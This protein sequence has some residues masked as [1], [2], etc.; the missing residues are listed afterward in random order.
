MTTNGHHKIYIKLKVE[1]HEPPL[2]P[3]VSKVL[4]KVKM[5]QFAYGHIP[6]YTERHICYGKQL[7]CFKSIFIVLLCS[8]L[9]QCN[10]I[11]LRPYIYYIFQ[12][13]F[14][15]FN[16]YFLYFVC[17]VLFCFV[18]VFVFFLLSYLYFE[19]IVFSDAI[20]SLLSIYGKNDIW[21]R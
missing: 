17:F 15:L 8:F 20:L 12:I 1:Q 10:C 4:R 13:I 21:Y 3:G 19:T 9:I 2:K 7:L 6:M 16:V 18:F 5:L 14:M 11:Q